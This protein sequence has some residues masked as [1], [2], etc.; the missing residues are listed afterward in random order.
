MCECA[1]PSRPLKSK[2]LMCGDTY[3]Y[4]SSMYGGTNCNKKYLKK[5]V[6]PFSING[7][8]D[9]SE[10]CHRGVSLVITTV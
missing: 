8:G 2:T 5:D 6:P 7:V 10:P 4:R 9:L 1:M 3:I